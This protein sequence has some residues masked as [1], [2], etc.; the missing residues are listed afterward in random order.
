[1]TGLSGDIMEA[2]DE[3]FAGKMM[4]D[5][6]IVTPKDAKVVSPV[7]GTVSFV[8][9]TK[10]AIGMETEDGVGL[11]L[12]VG[13]DTVTLNGEGFKVLVENGQKVKKGDVLMELDLDFLQKNAKS[14]TSPVIITDI[15]ESKI[16]VSLIA[17]GEVKAGDPLY[18]VTIYE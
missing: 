12:H 10:H 3:A 18:A 7:D 9:D 4:G 11:L 16:D 1:M 5:G 13:I 17:S 8:F 2:D 6:A 15:D 14:M